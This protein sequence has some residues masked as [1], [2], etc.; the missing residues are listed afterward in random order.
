MDHINDKT[1]QISVKGLFFDKDNKLMMMQE[2]NGLWELPGG[3]VQKGEDLLACLKR[4]CSEETG[5]ECQILEKQPSIVYAAIDQVGRPRLMLYYKI[6]FNSL[7]FTP[8]EEC[9]A[10]KFFSKEEVKKLKT[11]PQIEKLHEFL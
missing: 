8:S 6:S 3:R 5:L 7:D 4:E 10:I 11:F 9:V 2:N 1:F